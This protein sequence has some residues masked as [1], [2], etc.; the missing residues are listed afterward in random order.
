MV[1]SERIFFE[2]VRSAFA[3]TASALGLSGPS[4]TYLVMPVAAYRSGEVEYRMLLD[5]RDGTVECSVKTETD[6]VMFTVGIE[7][8]ALATQVV[9]RRGRLSYSARNLKQMKKSLLGQA[10]YVRLVHPFFADAAPEELM[11]Q[12][13]AREWLKNADS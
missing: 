7:A 1:P 2:E 3:E 12:A 10:E 4:E 6:S 5:R 8:L 13:G 9:D 11:R